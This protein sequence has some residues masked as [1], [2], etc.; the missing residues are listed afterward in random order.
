MPTKSSEIII[1]APAIETLFT[2]DE[3]SL[4]PKEILNNQTL[5]TQTALRQKLYSALTTL[6]EKTP[7][8]TTEIF[9]SELF[10]LLADFL[11]ADPHHRRLILYLPF[12]LIPLRTPQ[13]ERFILSYLQHWRELLAESDVRANFVDGNILE[14]ELA[15]HGQRMVKKAA[16]LI[17][18]L[19]KKGLISL[20]EVKEI[21]DNTLD[22]IL[23]ESIEDAI[24]PSLL[25]E[26]TCQIKAVPLSLDELSETITYE[27]KKIAMRAALDHSRKM[28]YARVVWEQKDREE[29]LISLCA[30]NIAQ[31]I[32]TCSITEKEGIS[33]LLPYAHETIDHILIRWVHMGILP[34]EYLHTL[35]I[36]LPKLDAFFLETNSL[37]CE[38]EEFRT[39]IQSIVTSPKCSKLL[40]PTAIFFGSRLKGYALKDADLDIAVFVKPDV[41]LEERP[42]IQRMLMEMFK[43]KKIDGKIVEFW[44]TTDENGYTIRNFPNPDI[45]LADSTWIHIP[46]AGVWLGEQEALKELHHNLLSGFLRSK[47]KIINRYDAR[48]LWLRN[49]EREV[50]QYRLMHKGYHRLFPVIQSA[51]LN[52]KQVDPQSAFWDSG[53][54]RLATLL[55]ITRVFL[56]QLEIS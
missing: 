49:I 46:F 51:L 29:K 53:Y 26:N 16:H 1:T 44:L 34:E 42:R 4:W 3:K 36:T 9:D 24:S 54:R 40:Y 12:E 48:T 27:L 39:S 21:R 7:H 52:T 56:P 5:V 2:R 47:D 8:P 41:P 6:F 33:F 50:L 13:S 37:G 20:S 43:S 22:A 25:L 11:D 28:P 45:L 10:D 23:K 38:I 32:R 14:P 18:Y 35:N 15:P 30:D 31:M 17:P 55:F 19:I